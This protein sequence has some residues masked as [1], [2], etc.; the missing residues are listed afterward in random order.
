MSLNISDDKWRRKK[1][2]LYLGFIGKKGSVALR[3]SLKSPFSGEKWDAH[4]CLN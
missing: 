1:I 3:I 2:G 4:N